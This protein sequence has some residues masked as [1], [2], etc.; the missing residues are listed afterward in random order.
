MATQN[1]IGSHTNAVDAVK[2]ANVTLSDEAR[3]IYSGAGGVGKDAYGYTKGSGASAACF[4]FA[5][6]AAFNDN[7]ALSRAS[8]HLDMMAYVEMGLWPGKTRGAIEPQIASMFGRSYLENANGLYR[9]NANGLTR[10]RIMLADMGVAWPDDTN[11]K[12][13]KPVKAKKVKAKKVKPAKGSAEA[14]LAPGETMIAD[15]NGT[16]AIGTVEVA[17]D[18]N[19]NGT[20]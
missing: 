9:L 5:L 19:A 3:R 6:N 4:V 14:L 10:A 13:E 11:G 17:D 12:S 20:I 1:I 8:A 15:A 7:A 18:E 2:A 16:L